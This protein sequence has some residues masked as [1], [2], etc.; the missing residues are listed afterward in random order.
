MDISTRVPLSIA[1]FNS[2]AASFTL[3]RVNLGSSPRVCTARVRL[4]LVAISFVAVLLGVACVIVWSFEDE[5]F[6]TSGSELDIRLLGVRPDASDDL[7]DVEGLSLSA[8][9]FDSVN[10]NAW[11]SNVLRRDFLFE[12]PEG[13]AIQPAHVHV[14]TRRYPL[15]SGPLPTN[16]VTTGRTYT[17]ESVFADA[18]WHSGFFFGGQRPVEFVD[19]T[20][21]FFPIERGRPEMRFAGPFAEGVTNK[22]QSASQTWWKSEL[23]LTGAEVKNG[24][25]NTQFLFMDSYGNYGPGAL[26]FLDRQ[27]KRHRPL[28]TSI[29]STSG[30][31]RAQVHVPGLNS[32]QIVAAEIHSPQTKTFH[33]IQVRYPE[34]PVL[35]AP[36]P[37]GKP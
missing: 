27:G 12:L 2:F 17:L 13:V 19:V 16:V 6:H 1:E 23:V 34:R 8:R 37:R 21:T 28:V 15:F 31:W 24:V 10:T 5:K 32:N 33:H 36:A 3:R 14:A 35:T 11:G 9:P 22:A 25:T 18:Y 26:S 20:L 7:Y 4:E 29:T 30:P